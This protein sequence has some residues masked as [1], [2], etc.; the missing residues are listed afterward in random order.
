MRYRFIYDHV[1]EFPVVTMCRVL[2]V[3]RS[4]Y[5]AWRSRPENRW[6]RANRQLL[7]RIIVT[8]Q[9]SQGRYGSPRVHAEL[10]AQ[11]IEC[12]H[13][14]VANIMRD[15]GI[16]AR[17]RKRRRPSSASD[18]DYPVVPNILDRQFD[19]ASS[20]R[21]WAADITYIPSA[22]GWLYLAAIMD[23]FSRRIVGWSLQERMTT[24]LALDA[25]NTAIILRQPEPGLLH[26]SDQGSQYASYEYQSVLKSHGIICSMSRRGDCYDNAAI[27]SFFRSLKVEAVHGQTNRPIER[28]KT[29]LFDYIEIFY[30]HQRRHSALGYLS[31]VEFE[32]MARNA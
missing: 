9:A 30:N 14:R 5:Y 19:A 17:Q 4:G 22:E 2:E 13:N 7:T 3:S 18:H 10:R 12:G 26:H 15:N 8:H 16:R 6:E 21:I 11:G 31:P 32:R 25:L 27:E 1:D 23:L 24:E 20:D 29:D 28:T